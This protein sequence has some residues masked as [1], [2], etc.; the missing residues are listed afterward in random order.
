MRADKTKEQNEQEVKKG[1][2]DY[3]NIKAGF[4]WH[5][6]SRERLRLKT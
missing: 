5:S 6:D 4:E 2:E 3:R 1:E